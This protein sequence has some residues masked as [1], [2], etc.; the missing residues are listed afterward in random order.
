[1]LKVGREN[2]RFRTLMA[3]QLNAAA[4]ESLYLGPKP[5][6]DQD[7]KED[8]TS[9]TEHPRTGLHTADSSSLTTL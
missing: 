2:S 3:A 4:G 6:E 9:K 7:G 8:E 5:T 1:M